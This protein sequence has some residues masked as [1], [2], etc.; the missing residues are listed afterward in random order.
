MKKLLLI[1]CFFTTSAQTGWFDNKLDTYSCPTEKDRN[2]CN[3]SCN[4]TNLKIEF[5]IQKNEGKVMGIGYI[6]NKVTGTQIY[7]DCTIFDSKN[8]SCG[9]SNKMVNGIWIAGISN[10]AK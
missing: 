8:W 10:C 5:K 4:K 2:S 9:E 7:D 6:D 1:L 3:S